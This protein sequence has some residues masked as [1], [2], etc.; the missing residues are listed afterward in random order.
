MRA[1]PSVGGIV[2]DRRLPA[3]GGVSLHVREWEP[4]DPTGTPVLL[5]HGLASC[6]A[7]WDGVADALAA[8]GHPVAAVDQ[9]GHG[10][11][12]KPD[13]G[14]DYAT[15][16]DDLAAVLDGLGWTRPVVAGQSWGGGVVLELAVRHPDATAGVACIDGGWM[17]F[18]TRFPDWDACAAALSPPNTTGTP[19]VEIEAMLRR[20]HPDWPETGIRGALACFEVR[21]DGTVAPWLT[22]DRH[23]Q[24]LRSMWDR[25]PAEVH[26]LVRVPVLLL[27]ADDGS[28]WS[29]QKRHDVAAAEA[30]LA[31]SRTHW[32][33]PADHDVHAQHPLEV[34]RVLHDACEELFA[35][36]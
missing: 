33:S 18:P 4:A 2:S 12:D 14:Y 13:T 21:E 23:L 26:P 35:G 16:A 15:V 28:S 31:R 34:A 6:A 25:P 24:I 19:V 29:E 9:R 8:R 30:A 10:R 1:N 17:D 27:P 5:V 7:L 22:R 11:S 32:F 20:L 3:T 36:G